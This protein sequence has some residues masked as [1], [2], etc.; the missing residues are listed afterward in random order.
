ML[1][2]YGL[3]CAGGD[4]EE[5]EGTFL[6]LAIK[7]LLGLDMKLKSNLNSSNKGMEVTQADEQL[8]L[9]GHAKR[10][11]NVTDLDSSV[12]LDHTGTT[13]TSNFEKETVRW[14]TSNGIQSHKDLEKENID[15]E[16]GKGSSDGL[17]VVVHKLDNVSNHNTECSDELTEDEREELELGIEN[18]LDQCFFCLYGLNLRS[19]SLSEEDLVVHKNTSRGDYQTKEQCADVFQYI[20]P[21]AKASS[22]SRILLSSLFIV[23]IFFVCFASCSSLPNELYLPLKTLNICNLIATLISVINCP[24]LYFFRNLA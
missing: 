19:D 16:C 21:Y 12:V 6:K 7:H 24:H 20:L 1:A 22:V 15:L 17:D 13:E 9:D 2:E 18:A 14:M 11:Q 3:C 4:G 10:S 23:Y 5:D 8:S